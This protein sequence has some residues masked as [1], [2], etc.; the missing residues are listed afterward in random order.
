MFDRRKYKNFAKMQL[1]KRW[2]IPVLI[3]L[4]CCSILFLLQLPDL[5]DTVTEINQEFNKQI[6]TTETISSYVSPLSTIREWVTVLVEFIL[7]F[8]Q[9][10]VYL[11]ISK[12]PEN[13]KFEK[14]LE[15]LSLWSKA[16]LA[17]LW[18]FLWIFLWSLLFIIPGIVKFYS[19]SQMFFLLI[20]YP[21]LSISQAMKISKE[22]TR[23]HKGDLFVMHLSFLGWAIL[24]V[25]PFGIGFL[26]LNP[27]VHMSMINAYHGLLKDALSVGII[28]LE[29]L[30]K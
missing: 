10:N 7:L 16:I 15:G 13:I 11:T 29:D 5:K 2:N 23:G 12:G 4:L 1:K 21:N 14:F 20:E 22:I 26:W 25:I 27:Y 24:A 9:L 18:N 8:A 3:T 6:I 30:N 28:K 17:G 19:Y